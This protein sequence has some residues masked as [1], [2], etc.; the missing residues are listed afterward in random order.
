MSFLKSGFMGCGVLLLAGCG[1]S[2]KP[3]YA[4]YHYEPE[5]YAYMQ[6]KDP[7]Q[8]LTVLEADEQKAQAKG[9]ALP[10]G[11]HAHLGLLYAKL[12]QTAQ[13][14][15]EF[16]QEKRLFPESAPYMDFVL[17]NMGAPVTQT[18]LAPGS[19]PVSAAQPDSVSGAKSAS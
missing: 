12:G 6:G 1:A 9:L 16:Q 11:F 7:Q 3:L 8:Q 15:T 2:Q 14:Q 13:A 19:V 4:W 10:P 17:R 18:Q 5:L